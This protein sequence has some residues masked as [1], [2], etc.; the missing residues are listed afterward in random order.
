MKRWHIVTG[1]VVL[2]GGVW[3]A[4]E[5]TRPIPG[6]QMEDQGREHVVADIVDN[7][8]YNS[9]PPTSGP[10]FEIWTKPGIYEQ[11]RPKGELIHSLEHGY[12]NINYNC[13]VPASTG[14]IGAVYAQ[15]QE[16]DATPSAMIEDESS[17]SA[18]FVPDDSDECSQLRVGL[19][20]VAK[21]KDL[22][23]LIVVPDPSLDHRIVLTAWTYIDAFDVFD[24]DR[25]IR[26][27]DFHRDHGPEQTME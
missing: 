9:N 1:I 7:T 3:F 22:Y 11:P 4:R 21:K 10:H 12:V 15:E 19:E 14:W 2:V 27:I 20:A 18:V 17:E 24:E 6:T 5:V 16:V 8:Q 23:K 13:D 25:I 26:F